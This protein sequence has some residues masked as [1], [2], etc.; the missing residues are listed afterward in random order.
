MPLLADYAAARK[1]AVRCLPTIKI[2]FLIICVV[3]A[4]GLKLHH[5]DPRSQRQHKHNKRLTVYST[6]TTTKNINY[7]H[8]DYYYY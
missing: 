7:Y 1:L 3:L 6:T 4:M 8:Y 2:A 5:R